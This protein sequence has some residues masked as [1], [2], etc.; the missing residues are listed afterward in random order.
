MDYREFASTVKAKYPEYKDIDDRELAE[1]IVAK[2]PVYKDQV[3]FESAEPSML[4]KA[5]GIAGQALSMAPKVA[6]GIQFL[7]NPIE[8]ASA[9]A[10]QK[11]SSTGSEAGEKLGSFVAEQSGR[12]GMNP[13]A[14]AA[15]GLAA[16]LGSDMNNWVGMGVG[17]AAGQKAAQVAGSAAK[18]VL[19][20]A[21]KTFANVPEEATAQLLK[22]PKHLVGATGGEQAIESAVSRLQNVLKDTR[23]LAG[24]TL[25]EYKQKIGIE[26]NFDDAMYNMANTAQKPPKSADRLAQEF[27]GLKATKEMMPAKDRL[28][29]LVEL[30][31]NID[32]A[33]S[34]SGKTVQPISDKVEGRLKQA[35]KQLNDM[36]ANTPG[37]K[38]L[39]RHER[40]FSER[41]QI[42][43][44]LQKK[45]DD[46]GQAEATLE[47][48]FTGKNPRAKDTRRAIKALEKASGQ[49]LLEPLFKEFAARSTNKWV[50]RPGV[51]QAAVT[52]GG[53]GA[54]FN[55]LAAIPAATAIASQS[56]RLWTA[57]VRGAAKVGPA[58]G[59]AVGQGAG[60]GSAAMI[61]Q[62]RNFLQNEGR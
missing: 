62:I 16:Q 25:G 6:Q 39:R 13:K 44:D 42:Y 50:G 3:S 17:G 18:K 30:R 33:V 34:F 1:R 58:I 8:G 41:A 60:F 10:A 26:T 54:W 59:K 9:L 56:P 53:T 35:A 14:G 61:N 40:T 46:P 29:A 38:E 51:V 12:H 7:A 2:H 48:L 55:P 20:G 32:E 22:D 21:M 43:D 27:I 52:L 5:K 37:G 31:Q 36:I 57:G 47:Q 23:A 19:P 49:E 11:L 24:K 4:D 15:L 45:L 28:K